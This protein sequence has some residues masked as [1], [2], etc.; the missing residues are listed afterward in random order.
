MI[1]EYKK[2]GITPL[3]LAAAFMLSFISCDDIIN[4][5]TENA[6]PVLNI[7]AWINNKPET[8]LIS[9]TFSQGYFDNENLPVPA[10]GASVI[11]SDNDGRQYIFQEDVLAADG[12][13]RWTPE[14]GETIGLPGSTYTLTV[15]YEQETFV[16]TSLMGRVPVVDS[17][18]FSK[19]ENLGFQSDE[20]FYQA[21]FWATDLPGKGDTYW[22]RAHKNGSLL[23]KAS[24]LNIAYD[25]GQTA[26]SEFDGVT[27]ITPIRIGINAND[28]DEDDIPLSPLKPGDSIYVEI[29]SLTEASFNYLQQVITQTDKNGGLS[30]LFT[31]TP[32]ANVSTNIAN[33]DDNGSPV[34]GFFNVA[35]VSGLGKRFR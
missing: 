9:L 8:Q 30:E 11:I 12:S 14:D 27:F 6:D 33:Q 5:D 13:Y 26:G 18:T 23:N 7:D 17:L 28:E 20:D 34:V 25:A 22:I 2:T 31:S 15:I 19:E 24:E 16:A 21:E 1:M 29:H 10:S 32:L 4:A 3:F 35:S